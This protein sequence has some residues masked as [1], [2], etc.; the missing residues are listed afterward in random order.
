MGNPAQSETIG[1]IMAT[2]PQMVSGLIGFASPACG[3]QLK[4]RKQMSIKRRFAT[5]SVVSWKKTG[6]LGDSHIEKI[7]LQY[8]ANIEASNNKE[9]NSLT[10]ISV[11]CCTDQII[12]VTSFMPNP[13]VQRH[14]E[15]RDQTKIATS[16][17]HEH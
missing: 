10:P 9:L 16:S 14:S 6:F 3:A 17:A 13:R 2:L 1:V 8:G 7:S 15:T 12:R 4:I 5:L 11:P